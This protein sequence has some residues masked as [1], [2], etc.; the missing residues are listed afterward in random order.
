MFQVEPQTTLPEPPDAR[1]RR[2][3]SQAPEHR[4]VLQQPFQFN[5]STVE[6]LLSHTSPWTAQP[7][8]YEGLWVLRGVR[9]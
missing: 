3:S 7:M 4:G 9:N 8:G 2:E 6:P 5:H 1:L